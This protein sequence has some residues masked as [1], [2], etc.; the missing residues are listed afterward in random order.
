MPGF[1]PPNGFAGLAQ[2]TAAVQS[3]YR[4]GSQAVRRAKRKVKQVRTA[5]RTAK[6]TARRKTGQLKKGSAEAKRYMAKIRKM[7]K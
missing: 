2:Q 5:A 4:R 7:R 6:R 3:L 1:M